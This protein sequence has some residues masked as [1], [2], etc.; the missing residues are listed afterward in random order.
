MEPFGDWQRP[1][2]DRSETERVFLQ[3]QNPA[4]V[5]EAL[6]PTSYPISLPSMGAH[7]VSLLL[8]KSLTNMQIKD[9]G[10]IKLPIIND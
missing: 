7:E 1:K 2:R 4:L 3:Y 10:V 6:V 5:P 8:I 9:V